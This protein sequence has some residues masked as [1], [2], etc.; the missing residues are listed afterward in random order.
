MILK[1]LVWIPWLII[2]FSWRRR[3]DIRSK[4]YEFEMPMM[5]KN[6][7][8]SKWKNIPARTEERITKSK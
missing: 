1:L 2:Y 8:V 6:L 5:K 7:L 4:E 3:Y